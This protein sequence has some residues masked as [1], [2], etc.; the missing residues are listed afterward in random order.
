MPKIPSDG[1]KLYVWDNGLNTIRE[2]NWGTFNRDNHDH[3]WIPSATYSKIKT[4]MYTKGD[5]R[6]LATWA[7]S[8]A[9]AH[10]RFMSIACYIE[11]YEAVKRYL[12]EEGLL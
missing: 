3:G 9:D 5:G 7:M 8:H 11:G 2:W 10:Q 12:G 6:K 4:R 1:R